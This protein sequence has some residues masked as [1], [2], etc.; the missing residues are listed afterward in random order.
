MFL[1]SEGGKWAVEMSKTWKTLATIL[2]TGMIV[3]MTF[4]WLMSNCARCL[5]MCAIGILL[6]SFFGGGAACIFVGLSPSNTPLLISGGVLLVFGL[7][8]VCM[9]WCNRTSLETAIA[10]IDASADFMID[11]KRL[12]LVSIMYFF[13]FVIWLLMWLFAVACVISMSKFEKP[14][15]DGDQIK[16]LKPDGKVWGIFIFMLFMFV[17]VTFFISHKVKFITMVSA[18]TYYFNNTE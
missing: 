9:L 11:T 8:T 6:L 15:I 10:I 13:V 7:L 4:M 1:E 2:F 5:A 3:A 17:W 16:D 18:A 12:I 14:A